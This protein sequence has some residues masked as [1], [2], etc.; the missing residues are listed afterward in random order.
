MKNLLILLFCA[1]TI[2]LSYAKSSKNADST[3]QDIEFGSFE[4]VNT[5][6]SLLDQY[7][8][9]K[10]TDNREYVDFT[11][12]DSII[13]QFPDSIYINR[14]NALNSA[15]PL[16]YNSIVRNY[17]H[18]YTEKKRDK[19]QE[20]LT[21]KEYYFPIFEEV[22]DQYEMP[23]EFRYLPVI[24]SALNPRA[25]SKAGAVGLWQFMYGTGRMYKL[26]VNS[27]MDERRDPI[28][29]SH[30]AAAFLKDLYNIY[31]DWILVIAA[32]NC[33]PGNVNKAI[34][35]AGGKRDYW[36]IYY[37]L[38]KETRGYVPAFMAAFYAINY[39]K[40]HNIKPANIEIPGNTDTIMVM[41]DL[42]L[43][44]VAA[45][46]NISIDKLRD[47][48][49]QYR[50]DIIPGKNQPDYLRIPLGMAGKFIDKQDKIFSFNDSIFFKDK[51]LL[52]NPLNY[53]SAKHAVATAS[54]GNGK[55]VYTVK[56]GDNLGNI[57]GKYG[58]TIANL[59]YWN[60]LRG[61]MIRTGQKLVIYT[62]KK[63]APTQANTAKAVNGTKFYTVR[64][65]DNLYTIARQYPGVK[66]TD[67]I[68]WNNL[69]EASRIQPGQKLK[70]ILD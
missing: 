69:T 42:H 50:M 63:G 37:Y 24:E 6:D 40:E 36:E 34:R 56:S 55:I 10:I 64:S 5:L 31:N 62:N 47:L 26:E 27:F 35:R 7:F 20:I 52:N 8:I 21:L 14:F 29:A 68:R 57:S 59:R 61:N 41:D 39:Y 25:V 17:I 9:E 65:G 30:A 45:V 33:G 54:S 3:S 67:I 11:E 2:Q 49:P 12:E 13:G 22:L 44:Q 4:D 53:K 46:L 60:N 28:K 15:I 38:P 32:Y 48:N 66:Y 58:V 1:L 16:T 51:S 18:V 43:G 19:L 70:I 23:L